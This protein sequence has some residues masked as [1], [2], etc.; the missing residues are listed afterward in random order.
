MIPSFQEWIGK[1][2]F[3]E[4]MHY[5]PCIMPVLGLVV[6]RYRETKDHASQT[7]WRVTWDLEHDGT[8]FRVSRGFYQKPNMAT[9]SVG[10]IFPSCL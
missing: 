4:H 5:G 7:Y 2:F 10:G 3:V 8:V 9:L 6:R 1:V